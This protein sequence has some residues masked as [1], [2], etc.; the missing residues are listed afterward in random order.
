MTVIED[1]LKEFIESEVT[2]LLGTRDADNQPEAGR[3]WGARVL[4][5]R[6]EVELFVDRLPAQRLLDNLRSTRLL[7]MTMASAITF[8]A[9]QIKGYCVEIREPEPADHAWVE[10]HRTLFTE[11]IRMRGLPAHV[12]RT[13]YSKDFVRIKFVAEDVFDQTPGARAGQRL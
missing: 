8:R 5:N 13:L 11:A 1:D 4:D 2:I 12:S 9:I 6:Q 3:G 7:A 10:R